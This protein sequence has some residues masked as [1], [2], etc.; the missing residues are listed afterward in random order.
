MKEHCIPNF[1]T[2]K[3]SIF[4]IENRQHNGIKKYLLQHFRTQ[5]SGEGT[6]AQA[7]KIRTSIALQ[8]KIVGNIGFKDR[9]KEKSEIEINDKHPKLK[10]FQYKHQKSKGPIHARQMTDRE[11]TTD[12]KKKNS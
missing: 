8:S 12:S 3:C 11:R 1:S 6:K 2:A 4:I 7:I 5:T 10:G 9:F